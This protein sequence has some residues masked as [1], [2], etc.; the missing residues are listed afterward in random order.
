MRVAR[1]YVHVNSASPAASSIGQAKV[2]RC[3]QHEASTAILRPRYAESST[4]CTH[5]EII[6]SRPATPIATAARAI[7]ARLTGE[8]WKMR[9]AGM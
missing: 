8:T 4:S 5:E 7:R 2:P 9:C 6:F 3:S 1:T